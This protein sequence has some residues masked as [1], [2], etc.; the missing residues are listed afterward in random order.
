MIEALCFLLTNCFMLIKKLVNNE[1]QVIKVNGT[2]TVHE[3]LISLISC[4]REIPRIIR[5]SRKRVENLIGSNT[6]AFPVTDSGK[7]VSWS[8]GS[9]GYF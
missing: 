5:I 7:K 3:P 2:N 8:Q 1:K 9:V 4:S 6:S